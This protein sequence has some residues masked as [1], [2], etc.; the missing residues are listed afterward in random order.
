VIALLL[1]AAPL[2]SRPVEIT[3][4]KLEVLDKEHRAIYRGHAKALRDSTSLSCQTLTV[5]YSESREVVRIEADGDVEA[6]DQDRRAWGQ[7]AV[8]ENA[9]GVLR[10]TGDPRAQSGERRVAGEEIT[11]TTGIDRL[12]VLKPRTT[13]DPN[14]IV[15]DADHLVLDAD[16]R[17][18]TWTGH[19]K[20]KKTT[21][22]VQAPLL[23][24]RYDEHGTITKVEARGGVDV[25]DKDRWA[26]GA[27][28]DY[29]AAQGRLV[30]TGKPEARQ[31]KSHI[32]GRTVTFVSGSDTLEVE[33][34]H[35][36]IDVKEKPKK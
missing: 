28:A 8:Y 12:E 15:I 32:T 7:H 3:A 9:T 5:I 30:V 27:R 17:V 24:A 25:R 2:L 11:F 33:D 22:L 29:D 36:I 26:Y 19:V 13:D 10:V 20:A 23:V 35:S 21:T 31:G 34:A 14:Q 6:Q 18:A 1:A 16:K 4:D